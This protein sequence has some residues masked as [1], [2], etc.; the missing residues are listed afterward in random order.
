LLGYLYIDSLFVNKAILENGLGYLYLF[1]H[2]DLERPETSQLL[3]AQRKAM[4]QKRGIWSLPREP[5]DYYIAKD[6]SFRL[7]RPGCSSVANL[8]PGSYRRFQT[9]EEGLREGLS[10]CRNCKP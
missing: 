10:P 3:S 9:R 2:N 7:H 1:R 6:N 8:K 4:E 5:E